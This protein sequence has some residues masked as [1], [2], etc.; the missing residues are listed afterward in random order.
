M[1]GNVRALDL[2]AGRTI[3]ALACSYATIKITAC[4]IFT[5]ASAPNEIAVMRE[6]ASGPS[7]PGWLV[8]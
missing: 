4:I 5:N 3:F 7:T 8:P 2:K 1:G 6:V